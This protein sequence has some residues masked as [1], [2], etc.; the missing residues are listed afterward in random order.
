[1]LIDCEDPGRLPGLIEEAQFRLRGRAPGPRRKL[2]GDISERELAVLR[3][4][5]GDASLREIA[6]TL[7]L[8]LNTV[9]THSRSIYRKL[10]AASR[11]QAVARGRELGL[12]EEDPQGH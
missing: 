10:G 9:K 6:S 1:M 12:L 2:A 5:P 3:L 8:S 4:L 11:E 7:Y